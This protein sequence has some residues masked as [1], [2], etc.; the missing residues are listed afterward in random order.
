M[1]EPWQGELGWGN[2]IPSGSLLRT[3]PVV[4]ITSK[5]VVN[6]VR[7]GALQALTMDIT[8]LLDTLDLAFIVSRIKAGGQTSRESFVIGVTC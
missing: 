1:L 8:A 3:L 2:G 6:C 7:Y 5:D 4:C